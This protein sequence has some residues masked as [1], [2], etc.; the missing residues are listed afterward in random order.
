MWEQ[1]SNPGRPVCPARLPWIQPAA[2]SI[3]SEAQLFA[4]A[5]SVKVVTENESCP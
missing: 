2:P 5:V 1:L 4:S 3:L